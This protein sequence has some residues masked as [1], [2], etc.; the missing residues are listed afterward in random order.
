MIFG[1]LCPSYSR[2]DNGR[3]PFVGKGVFHKFSNRMKKDLQNKIKS[4]INRACL[5]CRLCPAEF[6]LLKRA[7][8]WQYL[9]RKHQN[10]K[11][12]CAAHIWLW[13]QMLVSNARIVVNWFAR[14]TCV[15]HAEHIINYCKI[16][17]KINTAG[18]V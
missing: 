18:G 11:R 13:I 7:L 17:R 12:I 16:E 1:A 5:Y 8:K 15:K 6:N 4:C 9:K 14:I 10:L 3:F 2:T